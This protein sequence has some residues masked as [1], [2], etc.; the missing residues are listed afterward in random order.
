MVLPPSLRARTLP[1]L[2]LMTASAGAVVWRGSR[3]ASAT[4]LA[5]IAA[6]DAIEQ[7]MGKMNEAMKALGAGVTAENREAALSQLAQFEQAV[8]AAKAQTPDLAS[9]IDEKKRADFVADFRR[10]LLEALKLACDAEIAVVNGKYKEAD[11]LIK[12]KLSAVKSAGHS[13]F[14][15]EQ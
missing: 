3:E 1:V 10:T 15:K 12:N 13:K 2:L 6:N 4:P 8:I 14:K 9:T 7:A 11:A 5:G